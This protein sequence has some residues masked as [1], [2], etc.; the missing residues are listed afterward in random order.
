MDDHDGGYGRDG[1]GHHDGGDGHHHDHDASA[2]RIERLN[3]PAQYRYLSAEELR[4][5]LDPDPDWTLLDL[6]SGTGFY[7]DALA[8]VVDTVHAVD[9]DATMHEAYRER[10]R[11]DNVVPVEADV[12]D[13]PLP[14]DVA[15]AAVSVRTFHHGVAEALPEVAR[16]LRPGGRFVVVDWSAT[17]VG[18][19]ERGPPPA[20]CFDLATVQSMLIEA[21]FGVVDGHERRE[22]FVVVARRRP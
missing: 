20:D 7:T 2:T 16:L 15:D 17:G 13:V 3:D 22:T 6:G 18:D 8:P 19:R 12:G 21:G 11:P 10:G 9:V 5:H 14:D 4:R 1:D